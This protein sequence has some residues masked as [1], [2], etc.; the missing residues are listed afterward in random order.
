MNIHAVS[1]IRTLDP[2][3]RAAADLG[4]KSHGHRDQ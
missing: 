4:V 1:G 3:N 2:I